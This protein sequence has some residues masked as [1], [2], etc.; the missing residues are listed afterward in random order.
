[1]RESVELKT[2]RLLLRSFRMSDV[3]DVLG[4]TQD[5][6]WARYQVGIPPLP[7]TR[8]VAEGLVTMFSS[9]P[10]SQGILRIF[11]VVVGG[12]VIGEIC[13]NQGAEDR[14]ND[15]FELTYT[16]SR[17]HWGNGLAT[18]GARAAMNWAFRAHSSFHRMYAW[19]DPRNIG[20]WRVMEKIGMR[21]EGLLRSHL[22]WNGEFRDQLYY[23]ISRA[24]WEAKVPENTRGGSQ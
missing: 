15:R 8:E 14:G 24:E 21:R 9:P 22:K 19:C 5:P 2:D 20:S 6:E 16:L 7:Y 18:E 12:S 3:E 1:M 13:L 23:G 4:Y 11:A 10:D 17:Q